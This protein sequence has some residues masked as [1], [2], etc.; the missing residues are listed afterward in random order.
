VSNTSL[1]P[2]LY[3]FK[4]IRKLVI[5]GD[6]AQLAPYGPNAPA[7]IDSPFHRYKGKTVFLGIQHRMPGPIAAIISEI[8]YDGRLNSSEDK[9]SV[10][11]E[12]SIFWIDV[13][14]METKDQSSW[15]NLDEIKSIKKVF[16][17]SEC[18]KKSPESTYV[19]TLY[20]GQAAMIKKEISAKQFPGV[21]VG[22]VDSIQ[23]QERDLIILSLV[24][25]HEV[26]FGADKRRINVA[27]SRARKELWIVGNKE[28]WLEK[29][30]EAPAIA[31][32]A[33]I[34][35]MRT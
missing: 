2:I 22:T 10:P 1:L 35:T 12:E 25:N 30:N 6:P 13:V 18:Y 28:F 33:D 31:A 24:R 16:S 14:S 17:L 3:F 9:L 32:L 21:G 5:L 20:R 11:A 26:G 8:S 7:D 4:T 23:G 19:I 29:R 27:V 34:A 15:C